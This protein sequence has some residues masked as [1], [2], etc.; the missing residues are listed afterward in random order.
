M[1][2]GFFFSFFFFSTFLF[3]ISPN[4][5]KY[6]YEQSSLEQHYKI[7]KKEKEKEKH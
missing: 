5:A 4:L 6:S 2:G 7:A 1:K 3:L